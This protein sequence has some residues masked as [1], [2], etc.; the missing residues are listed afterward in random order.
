[1][2]Q[3]LGR[4]QLIDRLAE[5][6]GDRDKAIAI[7]IQRGMLE[8][9][10]KTLTA[11]GKARDAMTAEERAKDRASRASGKPASA[12]LYDPKTN[13]TRVKGSFAPANRRKAP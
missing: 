3:H 5:Q 6:V 9:D 1:M 8:S 11:K 4:H 2:R 12:Y 7:L 13:R 10:G